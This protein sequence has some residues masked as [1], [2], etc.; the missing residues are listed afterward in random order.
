MTSG[1]GSRPRPQTALPWVAECPGVCRAGTERLHCGVQLEASEMLQ[2][3]GELDV[4]QHCIVVAAD[5]SPGL[6]GKRETAIWHRRRES[7]LR[8]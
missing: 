7:G 6:V 1:S 4:C 2:S 8:P 5:K 3:G